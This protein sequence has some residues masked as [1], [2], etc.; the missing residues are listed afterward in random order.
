MY[1]KYFFKVA[2]IVGWGI[3]KEKGKFRYSLF[4][5]SLGQV[6]MDL[7]ISP[8]SLRSEGSSR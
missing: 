3:G 2:L 1:T 8:K 4:Y 6:Q 7:V 5:T